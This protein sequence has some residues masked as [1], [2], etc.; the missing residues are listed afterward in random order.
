MPPPQPPYSKPDNPR[1]RC[2]CSEQSDNLGDFTERHD[3]PGCKI[4]HA[5][6]SKGISPLKTPRYY[7]ST[8]PHKRLSKKYKSLSKKMQTIIRF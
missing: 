3:G 7:Q 4:P 8:N 5:E 6:S 1:Q 2:T